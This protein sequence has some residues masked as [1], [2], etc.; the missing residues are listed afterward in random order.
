MT[1]VVPVNDP[2]SPLGQWF[3]VTTERTHMK[4]PDEPGV[5]MEEIWRSLSIED[6]CDCLMLAF[7]NGFMTVFED[8]VYK[9]VKN[10]VV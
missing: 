4:C 6:R 10:Q 2:E 5:V 9:T 8:G 1:I 3:E 7:P